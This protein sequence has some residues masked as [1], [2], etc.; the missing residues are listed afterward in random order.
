MEKKRGRPKTSI[1]KDSPQMN[2]KTPV[3]LPRRSPRLNPSNA[4]DAA[5]GITIPNLNFSMRTPVIGAWNPLPSENNPQ[6]VPKQIHHPE[7]SSIFPLPQSVDF[8]PSMPPS[9]LSPISQM[10]RSAGVQGLA[11]IPPSLTPDISPN[12]F[13]HN[14][15][16]VR[17]HGL[18]RRSPRFTP[19][20]R[21]INSAFSPTAFWRSPVGGMKG[22]N[23]GG[24]LEDAPLEMPPGYFS[25]TFLDADHHMPMSLAPSTTRMAKIGGY[26]PTQSPVNINSTRQSKTNSLSNKRSKKEDDIFIQ[27]NS[28]GGN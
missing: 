15:G 25:G 2:I 28:F 27:P 18:L 22:S 17:N 24:G 5:N 11:L 20:Q 10:P 21:S 19:N 8:N 23:S 13:G 12:L 16:I 9:F 4:L 1:K 14:P 6:T 3:A 26:S 7:D